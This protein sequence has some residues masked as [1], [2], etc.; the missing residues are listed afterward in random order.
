MDEEKKQ[1]LNKA[2]EAIRNFCREQRF[3]EDCPLSNCNYNGKDYYCP[4]PSGW[5]DLD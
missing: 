3:C 4:A 1:E 2:I 5:P